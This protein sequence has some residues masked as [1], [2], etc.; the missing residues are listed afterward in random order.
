MHST[1]YLP[2]GASAE[3][4]LISGDC[5]E[6]FEAIKTIKEHWNEITGEDS[7]MYSGGTGI[8]EKTY[9]AIKSAY[10]RGCSEKNASKMRS[11]LQLFVG[12]SDKIIRSR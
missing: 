12:S 1:D 5:Q 3:D 11:A 6:M 2:P 9:T 10:F 4:A 7:D 8:R